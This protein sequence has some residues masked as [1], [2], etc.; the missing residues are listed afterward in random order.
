MNDNKV[1]ESLLQKNIDLLKSY[2]NEERKNLNLIFEKFDSCLANYKTNNTK[3]M[4]NKH[5][6]LKSRVTTI[7]S[8]RTKYASVLESVIRRYYEIAASVVVAARKAEGDIHVDES[9]Y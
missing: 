4:K 2:S 6:A 1:N 5:T 8:N 9:D 3:S 7:N